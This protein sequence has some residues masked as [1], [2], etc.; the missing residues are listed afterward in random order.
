MASPKQAFVRRLFARGV[1]AGDQFDGLAEHLLAVAL[2][3]RALADHHFGA[4]AQAEIVSGHGL[5]GIED[6]KRRTLESHG[7]FR[8]ADGQAFSRTNVE[9]DAGPTPG[10]D[11]QPQRGERLDLRVLG[12]A[13]FIAIAL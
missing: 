13:G 4:Q 6:G 5:V 11:V 10:V 9:R 3:Q 12:H 2:D 8:G 7:D 1:V